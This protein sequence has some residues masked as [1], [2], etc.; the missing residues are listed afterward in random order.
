MVPHET[1]SA[2]TDLAQLCSRLT[3]SAGAAHLVASPRRH[4]LCRRLEPVTVRLDALV[5]RSQVLK[6]MVIASN[7]VVNLVRP[8]LTADPADPV[9]TLEHD[10]PACGPVLRQSLGPSGSEPCGLA[11]LLAST[12]VRGL[13]AAVD[14]RRRCQRHQRGFRFAAL[15]SSQTR[16]PG[17]HSPHSTQVPDVMVPPGLERKKPPSRGAGSFRADCFRD[18]ATH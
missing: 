13:L 8:R 1:R 9:V 17:V 18:T 16:C 7:L 10:A 4:A 3:G 14:A 15:H 5:N 2:P 12:A 11:V 6:P